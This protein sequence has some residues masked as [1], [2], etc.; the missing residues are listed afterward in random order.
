[1]Y[2]GRSQLDDATLDRFRLGQIEMDYDPVI[3]A[4]VCPDR[5]LREFLQGVR[6]KVRSR[7]MR[8]NVSTRFL[9]QSYR[10]FKC[11]GWNQARIL[12]ALTSGWSEDDVRYITSGMG[13]T[14]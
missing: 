13:V 5:E 14:L 10:M 11:R 3:E 6:A 12:K 1:M 4:Q 8:R 7:K 2:V 9:A